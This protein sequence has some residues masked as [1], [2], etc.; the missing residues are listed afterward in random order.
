MEVLCWKKSAKIKY[1]ERILNVLDNIFSY[2]T[3]AE[4]NLEIVPGVLNTEKPIVWP[5]SLLICLWR[6]FGN[7]LWTKTIGKWLC[8]FYQHIISKAFVIRQ[9]C[10]CSAGHVFTPSWVCVCSA[11]RV[12]TISINI[13]QC[14]SNHTERWV[15][16]L[17]LPA[18]GHNQNLTLEV[19]TSL[20][21]THFKNLVWHVKR[22]LE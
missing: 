4:S 1:L 19:W 7:T 8:D 6:F 15:Q 2:M 13:N 5:I 10:I 9:A 22:R 12:S 21:S 3:R 11:S 14:Q 20:Q 18:V 16:I 17:C